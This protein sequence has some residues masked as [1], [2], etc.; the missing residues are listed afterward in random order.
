MFVANY[1]IGDWGSYGIWLSNCS[2]DIN[3][4]KCDYV[5][6]VTWRVTNSS[7]KH[8]HGKGLLGWLDGRMAPPLPRI[9]LNK[10]IGPEQWDIW[11]L[12]ASMENL[13]LG[14]DISQ[15]PV[16]IIVTILSV[17]IIHILYKLVFPFLLL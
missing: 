7:V 10:Q 14:L 4:T 16:I 8:F 11:K 2:D 12:A 3:S 5:T 13:K 1:T 17:V 9:V 6:Q 15:R